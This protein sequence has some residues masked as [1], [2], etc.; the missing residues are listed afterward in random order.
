MIWLKNC[1]R[2]DLSGK[3]PLTL[4]KSYRVC[5]SHFE[6][7]MYFTDRLLLH[8]A[9]PT[10]FTVATSSPI[11]T[12]SNTESNTLCSRKYHL[13]IYINYYLYIIFIFIII[14]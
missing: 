8:S 2:M 10:I 5:G 14:Y 11:V 4:N 12:T 1:D 3:S 6:P 7:K 13:L 9:V